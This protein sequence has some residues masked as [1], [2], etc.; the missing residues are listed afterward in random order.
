MGF[1][2]AVST[3]FSKYATFSGRARRSEFWYWVLFLFIVLIITN[4][5]DSLLGTKITFSTV[6]GASSTTY[7]NNVGWITLVA[8]LLLFLPGLAVQVRRLH[9][10]GRSG[11]WWWLNIICCIGTLI[12]FIMYLGDS[13]TDNKYG[14]SPKTA[15][16]YR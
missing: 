10:T 15:N 7:Y 2:T 4:I 1:G 8:E 6:G 12:L 16:P 14:P 9:D 13:T 5:L 11:W 3:C